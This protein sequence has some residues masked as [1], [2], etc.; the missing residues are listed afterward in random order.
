MKKIWVFRHGPKETGPSKGGVIDLSVALSAE[1]KEL[2]KQK[3]SDFLKKNGK[4]RMI[5]TSFM[6]RA[7]QSAMIFAEICKIDPPI[8]MKGLAYT[9]QKWHEVVCLLKNPTSYDL[10]EANPQL[11]QSD[12]KRFLADIQDIAKSLNDN[13]D[14]KVVCVSHGGLIETSV[15]LAMQP[16]SNPRAH[17]SIDA[18]FPEDLKEGEAMIFIFDKKNQL[19]E[20]EK[21]D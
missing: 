3:A 14:E 10:Y 18:F 16:S 8:I 15:A 20:I 19:I 13:D 2:I 5:S 6:V 12:A 7:Y 4:P 1:G 9:Y 17:S 11:A 21:A